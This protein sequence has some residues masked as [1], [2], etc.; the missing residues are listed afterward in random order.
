ML[1]QR[2]VNAAELRNNCAW[3][4][5]LRNPAGK[6]SL[7]GPPR[8]FTTDFTTRSIR[9]LVRFSLNKYIYI[10]DDRLSNDYR[11]QIP[12]KRAPR[13]VFVGRNIMVDSETV[14]CRSRARSRVPARGNRVKST[15]KKGEA[16][17]GRNCLW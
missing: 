12:K 11:I 14:G 1:A 17:L 13:F 16:M 15:R 7:L 6:T 9:S 3:S 8:F 5:V 4:I 10:R 2:G